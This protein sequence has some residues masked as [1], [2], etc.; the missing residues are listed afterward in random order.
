MLQHFQSPFPLDS[1]QTI[2]RIIFHMHRIQS[3]RPSLFRNTTRRKKIQ[4]ALFTNTFCHYFSTFIPQT[5]I[6][7]QNWSHDVFPPSIQTF[8]VNITYLK[9]SRNEFYTKPFQRRIFLCFECD[10]T[11]FTTSQ[12]LIILFRDPP[13]VDFD[14]LR[15]YHPIICIGIFQ[16]YFSVFIVPLKTLRGQKQDQKDLLK[17]PQYSLFIVCKL[18]VPSQSPS[19]STNWDHPVQSSIS[20]R[21]AFNNVKLKDWYFVLTWA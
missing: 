11:H 21:P 14:F 3:C 19:L 13:K 1:D 12:I 10:E 15:K 9:I 2:D 6:N 18:G 5:N 8:N 20:T 17:L 7:L 4:K 16:I